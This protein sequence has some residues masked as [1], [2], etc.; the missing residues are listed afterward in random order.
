MRN[1][2][3]SPTLE[4]ILDEVLAREGGYVEDP[5][6]PGGPTHYGIT[7]ATLRRF[8]RDNTGDGAI[9]REDLKRLTKAEAKAIL[10]RHYF[11][12]PGLS[13]LPAA[14]QA[15]V[16]DMYVN[17]GATAISLLQKLVT[18][19]GFPC[20][21]DGVLGPKT[22]AAVQA[23]A[24]AAPGH[25]ADAYAIA[26]RNFYYALADRRPASRK[27]AKR[28]DGGKG[29]WILRAES[30]MQPRYRLSDAAHRERTKAWD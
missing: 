7:L 13:A 22:K 6:D 19:M 1:A 4:T 28:R 16:F 12:S 8:G 29:G 17:A 2:K 5:S 25:I 15:S 9:G 26:R 14:L 30:F 21:A 3:Q 27:Y 24:A 18:A 23:A 11:E 20:A 10:R